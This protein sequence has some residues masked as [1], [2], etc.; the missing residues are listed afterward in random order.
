MKWTIIIFDR[1]Y[2][3]EAD[4]IYAAKKKAAEKYK[5]E[6]GEKLATSH[7]IPA[8]KSKADIDRRIKY[9]Y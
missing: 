2:E 5:E 1:E 4:T 3:E 9:N 7:L 8:C 6:T